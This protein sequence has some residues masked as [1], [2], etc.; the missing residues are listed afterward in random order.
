[1]LHRLE[2]DDYWALPGGRVESGEDAARTV[3]REMQEEL[4]E[5]VTCGPLAF[6]VENFFEV[7]G[8]PNH[9]L[10]FYFKASLS[11]S[12]P[13]L[14]ASRSHFGCEGEQT[15]EFRWFPLKELDAIDVRPSF[16][17]NALG[18]SPLA[19]EH[20]VQRG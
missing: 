5:E 4:H 3:V 12:S 16:L 14:D 11:E 20:V 2:H 9:E 10:G 8:K 6:A 1:M 18:R 7:E 19:F 15:L 17:R 13:L